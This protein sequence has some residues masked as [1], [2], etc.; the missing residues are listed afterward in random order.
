MA[1]FSAWEADL[2]GDERER[3]RAHVERQRRAQ[4]AVKP[5]AEHREAERRL[6]AAADATAD[7][8]Q[9]RDLFRQADH[10]AS[11]AIKLVRMVEKLASGS[12]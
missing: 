9:T 1:E 8:A 2:P 12:D 7:P 5:H 10:H 3:M 4:A 11:E 6:R